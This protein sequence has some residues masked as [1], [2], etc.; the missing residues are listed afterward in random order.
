MKALIIESA[1]KVSFFEKDRPEPSPHEVL[2]KV[3]AVA[4]NH[5]DQYIRE[6]NYPGIKYGTTLGADAC[7]V[8][9]KVGSSA[10]QSL[11]GKEVIINPN[12]DWGSNPKVQS[13]DYHILGTPHDGV[14]AEYLVI[15][16]AKVFAKPEHLSIEEAAALPLAGMTAFRALFHHGKLAANEKVLVTGIGGGVAQFALQFALAASADVYVTSSDDAKRS[17][18]ISLGAKKTYD[19]R[20]KDWA[21]VAK[22]EAGG[23]DVVIDSAGGEGLNDIIQLM[24]PAGRIVFYGATAGKPKELDLFRLFWNQITLQGS[25]MANDQ[26]F[27]QMIDFVNTHKIKPI[28][29]SMLPF[30][31]IISAFDKMRAGKQFGKLVVR[32]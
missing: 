3:K 31:E 5:R 25:T 6:G 27:K 11:V 29:D 20:D 17:K 12:V 10:D 24:N 19:Y 13:P 14:F 23:F 32:L 9:I 16:E 18:C 15:N 26:E 7:G 22:K 21:K 30:D 8:V 28:I 1:G 4:L 2:I